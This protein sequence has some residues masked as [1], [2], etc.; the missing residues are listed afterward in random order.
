LFA[1]GSLA[2]KK[3]V[4]LAQAAIGHLDQI[5]PFAAQHEFVVTI[6]TVICGALG[7]LI[8]SSFV[9]P[10][11]VYLPFSISHKDLGIV[12]TCTRLK[13]DVDHYNDA[14]R[15]ME[16]LPLILDFTDDVAELEA[17]RERWAGDS[18]V[19]PETEDEIGDDDDD[20]SDPY[21]TSPLPPC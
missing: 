7:S 1:L 8:F 20:P 13:T 12:A 5:R 2:V 17:V 21:P 3:Y 18:H 15:E 6:V 14:H 16:Q 9:F 19:V 4:P 11:L 10:L